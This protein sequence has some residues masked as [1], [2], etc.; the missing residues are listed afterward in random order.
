MPENA[1]EWTNSFSGP[2]SMGVAVFVRWADGDDAAVRHLAD[3]QLE[4]DGG[5]MDVEAFA[6]LLANQAQNALA[7]GRGHVGD[8]HMAGKRVSVAAD[9][10]HVQIVHIVHSRNGANDLLNSLQ[11]HAAGR[12]LQQD[13]EEIIRTIPGVNDV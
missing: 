5:V 12:A 11:L 1:D 6:H 13:V 9:A 8:G 2:A 3:R 7:L 10:P 4:L